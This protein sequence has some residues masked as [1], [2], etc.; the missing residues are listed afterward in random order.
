MAVGNH[1]LKDRGRLLRPQTNFNKGMAGNEK[2]LQPV[3]DWINVRLTLPS[4]AEVRNEAMVKLPETYQLLIYPTDRSGNIVT[5][6][7]ADQ[8]EVKMAVN[9]VLDPPVHNYKIVGLIEEV[10]KNTKL[11]F[12]RAAVIRDTEF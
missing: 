11:S 10:R 6:E 8:F 12:Y 9:G 2:K 3:G 5:L 4:Q 1:L 7:Q